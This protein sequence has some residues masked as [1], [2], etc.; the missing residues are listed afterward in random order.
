MYISEEIKLKM[1]FR[2]NRKQHLTN[3]TVIGIVLKTNALNNTLII[4]FKRNMQNFEYC[5]LSID[6]L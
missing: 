2:S 6:F 1:G 3:H 4:F 5:K